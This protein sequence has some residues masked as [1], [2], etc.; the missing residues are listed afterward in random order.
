[1]TKRYSIKID[2]RR[3]VSR[4]SFCFVALCVCVAAQFIPV[5]SFAQFTKLVDFGST[6]TLGSYP[7]GSLISDGT[8]L[9]GMTGEGGAYGGGNI[10]KIKA[11]GTGYIDLYDF[12]M[13]EGSTDGYYPY[14]SLYFD[15]AYLY[16]MTNQG[17]TDNLGTI[18]RIKTDGTGYAVLL[19]FSGA[20][21][22]SYPGGSLISDGTF[23]YGTTS[24]GGVSD[25]GTLFKIKTDG[26]NYTKLYDFSGIDGSYP[27]ADLYF[28]GTF[29]Y[30]MATEGGANGND[31]TLF[32]IKPDGSSFT[33]LLDFDGSVSGNFPYGSLFSDGTF[34][35]GNTEAGGANDFG[36]LFKIKPDGTGYFKMLDFDS[37]SNG[38]YPYGTFISDGTYL[39]AMTSGGG[40]HNFGT[41]FK[42]KP[43]GSS[44]AKLLDLTSTSGTYPYGSLVLQGGLLYGMTEDG[45]Q[46]GDGVI[47]KIQTNGAN[48]ATLLDFGAAQVV[49]GTSPYGSLISDGTFLYGMTA[50][51]GSANYGTV[52][53]VRP[54]GTGYITLLEFSGYDNEGTST[55][56]NPYGSLYYDGSFLYG[57]TSSGGA[58]NYGII[59][60]MKTDGTGYA[61][62]NSFDGDTEGGN[63]YG[64]LISDGT[65]LYGMTTSGGNYGLGTIFQISTD[66]YFNKLHDFAGYDVELGDDGANPYGDLYYDG[67][68]LYGLAPDGGVHGSGVLFRLKTDGSAYSIL[69]DFGSFNGDGGSPYGSLISDGTFLYGMTL[70]GGSEGEGTV[71]KIKPDGT[72]Y[73][74]LLDFTWDSSGISD[75]SSPFGSL[76]YD[77]TFLYGMTSAGSGTTGNTG[78]LFEIKPDG[79]G[80][81]KLNDFSGATGIRPQ[82]SLLLIGTTLYGMTQAG[83]TANDGTIFNYSL[84]PVATITIN[85]QPG[86]STVCNGATAQFTVAA[87]GTTNLT[88]QW[89][90]SV[91]GIVPF[92]D[93]TN[94]GGY[95]NATTTTLSVNTTGN[96][97]A[98][99]YR[100]K[101]NGDFV[102]TTFTI[103]EGLTINTVPAAPTVQGASGC[104]GTSV[105]LTASGGTDGQYVWYTVATGGTSIAGQTNG[106]YTTPSLTATTTYYVSI[107]NGNCESARTSVIATINSCLPI[108]I[109][110]Q[111][112]NSTV[113]NG[114][115][116]QF[117]VAASGPANLTYQWQ[118]SVDGVVPFTDVTNG[119]GYSGVAT[120]TLS[121]N[122]TG[123]F[124][125]G[126]YRCKINGDFAATMFTIDAGLSIN[127]LPAAPI[128]QGASAC[129][130]TSVL[131]TASGG[132]NG[133]Y[134]WYTAATGGT[135]IVGETNSTYT[136]PSLTATTT[137]YVSI[138]NG[139]CE[140]ARTP[141]IA[142]IN[143]CP[144]PVITAQPLVTQIGG[145]ITLNLVSLITTSNST[146]N[147]AS[148]EIVTANG[149]GTTEKLASGATASIDASGVL[150]IN[151]TGINFSGIEDIAIQ[152]CDNNG[153]CTTQQF[154]IDV[155]GDIIVYNG[156]SPNGKN[157]SFIIQ[158]IDILPDTKIN[159]VYIFDRWENQVWHGNNYDNSS[160]VFTGVS[161]SGSDLPSGVYFYKIDFHSGR[162]SKT[163]FISLRRQ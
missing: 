124:G 131:L 93:I 35:Y 138:N 74:K 50:T 92:A 98:G 26:T 126:R 40:A 153:N 20:A 33:K 113:C 66:N 117:T 84:T 61:T 156:V 38:S 27:E 65:N 21:N 41:I 42:I 70:D 8:Y 142:T 69:Y 159:S 29:L 7:D 155:A 111:P 88:Y 136:T 101:I 85:S 36:T 127:P 94:G 137:Y 139:N 79:T 68:Y 140:S 157:P 49:S 114:A 132:A 115:T 59:F 60:R 22:G 71:F 13:G 82:G 129:M 107:N 145:V 76:T 72:A 4:R 119:S 55:G 58:Y 151:Y 56:S 141:V 97:G 63:P 44:F 86:N 64:S 39:Y 154:S 104:S 15:G 28:D 112:G 23:L 46:N 150:T 143:S 9:Y 1:M 54:D 83:G 80:Y 12:Y 3:S 67:T 77:G 16:G 106:T 123:D 37:A 5:G 18:F 116:A 147:F 103:D 57:M 87:S 95:S 122:T 32:K 134:V 99:R 152:A 160:V 73:A 161:D 109:N 108:T 62:L 128:V 105:S 89:Q 53:K 31:G 100:C 24:S 25:L 149:S 75:G 162:K 45:G 102:A 121:V 43:D 34:L 2:A 135:S 146:I 52:F 125:A 96:F 30:G 158:Y 148:L 6:T 81:K 10:F 144:P 118:Y 90:Y 120:T 133:E 11:D 91:D 51:G 48:F 130:G 14:A 47:F 110:T 17:G 163:G 19:S 78:I